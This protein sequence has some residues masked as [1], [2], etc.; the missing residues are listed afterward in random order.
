MNEWYLMRR[1]REGGRF[2]HVQQFLDAQHD[3]VA[4][5]LSIELFF[6]AQIQ[7]ESQVCC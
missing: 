4:P 2:L 7:I 3:S 6:R 5:V 1:G